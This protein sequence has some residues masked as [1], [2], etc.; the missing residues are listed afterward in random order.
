M[1]LWHCFVF[2][3]LI[4]G[5][6]ADGW[7]EFADNFATDLAPLVTLFGERLTKQFLSESTSL[8]DNLIFALSPL[9]ILTTVVSV[10]RI[11]GTSSLRAFVGRAN[12]G[13]GEAENELLSCVSG[14]TAELFNDGGISRVFGRPRLLEIVVWEEVDTYTKETSYKFGKLRDALREGT[15]SAKGGEWKRDEQGLFALPELDIP[16]LSLNKGIK[17]RPRGWFYAAASLGSILQGGTL[18][19]SALTVFWYSGIFKKGGSTENY[20]FPLYL[21]GS[22]SLS[23]GMFLCAFLIERSS[24]ECYLYPEKPS[25]IYWLQ[26]GRQTIGEQDFGAFLAVN[27]GPKSQLTRQL[28]YIKSIRGPPPKGKGPL[29]V[30]SICITMFGFILQFVGLRGMH[31]SVIIAN[32][33]STLLMAVVRTCLRTKRIGSDANVFEKED[34]ELFSNNQQE[35]DCFALH[36]ERVESFRL[37]SGLVHQTTRSR[38]GS[39]S[40]S[41]SSMVYAQSTGLGAR[42]I[43]TRARLAELTSCSNRHPSMDWEDLP[44]RKVAQDLASAI[45]MT[46]DV[47]SR[48]KELS[49]S[50]CSFE[51]SFACQTL[52]H[53]LTGSSL[54]TYPIFLRRSDDTFQWKANANDLEAILG[55]WTFSLLKSDPKWLQDRLGRSVGLTKSEA[56]SEAADLYFQKWIFRQREAKMVSSKMISF[57]EQTFGYYSD[58]LP[59]TKEILVV[60]TDNN[61]EVMAAQDIYI[62]FLMSVL[63]GVGSFGGEVDVIPRSQN[64]FFAQSARIDEL[65]NCF[66]IGNLGSREDALLCIVPVLRYHNLLPELAADSS[67]VRERIENLITGSNSDWDSAFSMVQWLCERCEGEEFERSTY[68]LGLL[69]Q[70]AMLHKDGSVREKGLRVSRLLL[71]TDIRASFF[72]RRRRPSHWMNSLVQQ[73]WWSRFSSQ[74]GWVTWHITN[75]KGDRQGM[76][77]LEG[78]GFSGDLGYQ[79]GEDATQHLVKTQEDSLNTR[80][81]QEPSE[82]PRAWTSQAN[83]NVGEQTNENSAQLTFL[84]WVIPG[85][86]GGGNYGD[87]GCVRICLEWILRDRQDALRHWIIARWAE[88]GRHH[89]PLSMQ[90][91]VYAASS[92][93]AIRTLRER[94]AD[95]NALGTGGCTALFELVDAANKEASEKLL[96][97]GADANACV[98]GSRLPLLSFAAGKGNEEISLLLL[99]YGADLELCD[100]GGFTPLH[101]AC[102]ENRLNTATLLLERGANIENIARDGNTP[103]FSAVANGNVEM[104]QLLLKNGANIDAT[105][106]G[107]GTALM[108][109]VNNGSEAILRLLLDH[110]AN[111]R[112]RDDL[113]RTALDLARELGSRKAIFNALETAS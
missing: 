47:V 16:N 75:T 97:H 78:L 89:P 45:E 22:I 59:D 98:E 28:T 70:R 72:E 9:G 100:I 110:G 1:T 41:D 84:G 96:A 49:C 76:K 90:A 57:S 14:A 24:S 6:S 35:L 38:S 85:F 4:G 95:I 93:S 56:S 58:S 63:D 53:K 29:L 79:T 86:G 54:E 40:T 8:L 105:D 48:W 18:A 7:D 30:F 101:T 107:R 20:A 51:L 67:G 83:D 99:D 60:K 19:Y 64:S 12:E 25:K 103:L 5:V 81:F 102:R 77:T 61:L 111:V 92:D 80:T 32:I 44:I 27:E 65:V 43:Q 71:E 17:R 11:C 50:S 33:G 104:L 15:W 13:P 2:I 73:Q 34:Q 94:G 26:P 74:L 112:K 39:C 69:C 82:F 37:V 88:V 46:M 10:I 52:R 87:E 66:E 106:N 31:P 55:L 91:F 62:Q 21:Y 23:I 36:L 42:L 109:A 113:G 108:L 3:T 68:E